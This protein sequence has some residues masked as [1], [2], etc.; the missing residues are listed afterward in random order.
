MDRRRGF[1]TIE[2]RSRAFRPFKIV[3][4]RGSDVRVV[5]VRAY[6]CEHALK[7]FHEEQRHLPFR[8]MREV[9]LIAESA[10]PKWRTSGG[11]NR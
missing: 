7:T 3:A 1:E 6:D 4:Q 11:D 5:T 2:H 8:F 10:L 9:V